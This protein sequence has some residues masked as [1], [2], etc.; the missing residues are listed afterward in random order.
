MACI[1]TA[2]EARK[3]IA[4]QLVMTSFAGEGMDSVTTLH[5]LHRS[6]ATK[7]PDAARSRLTSGCDPRLLEATK[8]S[9]ESPAAIHSFIPFFQRWSF[10]LINPF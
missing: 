9:E 7:S 3:H 2:N 8:S 6:A 10:G 4:A 1:R 5:G